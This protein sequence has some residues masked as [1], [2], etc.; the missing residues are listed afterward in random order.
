MNAFLKTGI[1][2]LSLTTVMILVSA[3]AKTEEQKKQDQQQQTAQ[4]K[5]D[6]DKALQDLTVSLPALRVAPEPTAKWTEAELKQ[7]QDL[8][9]TNERNLNK[10]ESYNGQNGVQIKGEASRAE[11]RKLFVDKRNALQV[12][13]AE[14]AKIS[15]EQAKKTRVD[16]LKAQYDTDSNYLE[17]AGVPV[18]GWP[19]DK[20]VVYEKAVQRVEQTLHELEV[21]DGQGFVTEARKVLNETRKKLVQEARK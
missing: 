11:T 1:A 3:C 16:Q 20:L 7:Y 5:A 9:D 8:I 13:R 19:E 15:A 2:A 4:T 14:Q 6:A 18:K 21:T 10:F 12:A 17:G